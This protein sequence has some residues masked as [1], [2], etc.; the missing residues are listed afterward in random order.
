MELEKLPVLYPM[1][2]V[3]YDEKKHEL[4]WLDPNWVGERKY[5]GFRYLIKKEGGK[6]FVLSRNPSVDTGLPV[7]KTANV[8]HLAELFAERLPD[9]S[10]IDGEIITH[11]NCESHEVTRIMGCDPDKA[12]ARQEEEG[13]VKFVA[14]DIIFWRGKDLTNFRYIE[15]RSALEKVYKEIL[16]P[17]EHLILAPV[18]PTDKEAKYEEIVAGG[19]EGLVLKNIHSRYEYTLDPKK[20]KKPKDTWIKVKKYK[21][22]DAVIMDFPEPNKEYDGKEIETW[23]YW[24]DPEGNPF[25]KQ[26]QHF[27]LLLDKGYEPVKKPYYYDWIGGVGFGQYN[28]AGELVRIGQTV[29]IADDVKQYM[30]DNKDTLIGTV[31]EVGAMRQNKKS[32]ALV[33]PRFI[34]FR[35]D[36]LPEQCMLGVE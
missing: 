10:I 35:E 24:V 30:T 9:G 7:D 17:S 2:A 33:H 29:G 5:D 22:F 8:P 36:K 1:G 27:Q 6:V 13:W 11:E 26:N 20:V 16:S 21:T 34:K 32:G 14:F 19:G 4:A 31:I 18:Y 12:I 23:Q 28:K 25:Y 3:G 15:R